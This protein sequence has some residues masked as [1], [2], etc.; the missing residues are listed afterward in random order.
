MPKKTEGTFCLS[1]S[2]QMSIFERKILHRI[3]G[4]L[5]E[6]KR[7]GREDSGGRDAI[8]N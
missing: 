8:E 6:G 1:E 7:E 4:P 2:V 5:R 3:Y